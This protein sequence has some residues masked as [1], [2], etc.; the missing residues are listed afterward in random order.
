MDYSTKGPFVQAALICQ[1]ALRDADG[2]MSAIRIVDRRTQ[3]AGPDDPEEMPPLVIDD[4]RLVVMLKSGAARGSHTIDI[5]MELP[6]GER[7]HVVGLPA[8]FEGDE[9]GVALD[10][11]LDLELPI[12]GL[13]WFD[14][15]MEKELLTRVP[16]RVVYQRYS[17]AGG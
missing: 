4:L 16:L 13:Y 1:L 10:A 3:V 6:S 9:K 14:L 7:H 5:E 17:G 15:S 8:Y 11:A 2:V 12:E